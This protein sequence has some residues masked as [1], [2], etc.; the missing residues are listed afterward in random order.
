MDS[1]NDHQDKIQRNTAQQFQPTKLAKNDSL[2]DKTI[3]FTSND[4]KNR[5]LQL[6]TVE[7]DSNDDLQ[8]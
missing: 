5:I 1:W 2:Q 7:T 3:I 8:S 4:S 6:A